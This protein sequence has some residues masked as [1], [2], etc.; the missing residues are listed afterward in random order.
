MRA[1]R[2]LLIVVV[3]LGGLFAIADRVAVNFAEGEAAD[4]LRSTENLASTPDVSING[5]PFLTQVV[6]GELDDVEIGIDDYEAS[7]GNSGEKIRIDGL[8]ANMKGVEFS[9]DFSSATAA[10]ATGTATVGYDELMKAAKSEPTEIAPGITAKVI[11]LSD[12]GNGKI[13]VSLQGTAFGVALPEPVE[14]LSSVTVKDNDVEV[15]ADGLPE[16]GGK[17][18]AESRIRAITD[19]QQTI[20]ELPGGI[21]LDKVEAAKDGVEISVKGSNVRLAG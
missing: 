5:F 10:T 9:S 8:R 16:I 6:G 14:V 18:L 21:E 12:G 1:L 19:F 15:V 20:D 2:I 7:T 4:K 11:G 3:I 13:K 17:Q